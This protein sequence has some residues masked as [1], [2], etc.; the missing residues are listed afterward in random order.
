MEV[1]T[2]IDHNQAIC[3][4]PKGVLKQVQMY[5]R[6]DRVYVPHS[7]G[8]IEV[9]AR[10]PDGSFVTSHPDVKVLEHDDIDGRIVLAKHLGADNM[11]WRR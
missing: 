11:R 1:F 9:R 4:Y 3:R 6:G 5:R 10:Q 7:G 8:F 2:V